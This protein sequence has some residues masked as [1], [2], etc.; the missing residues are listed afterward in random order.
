MK[1]EY[2]LLEAIADLNKIYDEGSSTYTNEELESFEYEAELEEDMTLQEAQER[3]K[4]KK[5]FLNLVKQNAYWNG[6]D[7]VADKGVLQNKT[8]ITGN[9]YD[10]IDELNKKAGDKK[11]HIDTVRVDGTPVPYGELVKIVNARLRNDNQRAIVTGKAAPDDADPDASKKFTVF[12][13]YPSVLHHIDGNHG[14]N[15]AIKN[16]GGSS[17]A[18]ITNEQAW[19]NYLLIEAPSARTAA[20]AH[21][22]IHLLAII[23]NTLGLPTPTDPE[24]DNVVGQIARALERALANKDGESKLKF[25]YIVGKNAD[26]TP[27]VEST[28]SFAKAIA[29]RTYN[30]SLPM[31]DILAAHETDIKAEVDKSVSDDPVDETTPDNI[32]E[33]E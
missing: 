16:V 18:D 26:G 23:T 14:N 3:G 7:T 8:G 13:L 24:K 27:I 29:T 30:N 32:K 6:K 20:Y 12:N 28:E 19:G 25:S 31:N 17:L 11:N 21:K 2:T 22:M 10:V 15:I 1:I 4:F 5:A 9:I 33:E